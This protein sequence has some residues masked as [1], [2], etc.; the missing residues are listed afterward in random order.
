MQLQ[1]LVQE[2]ESIKWCII[3]SMRA[4]NVNKV[5]HGEQAP[6]PHHEFGTVSPSPLSSSINCIDAKRTNQMLDVEEPKR[7]SKILRPSSIPDFLKN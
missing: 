1:K 5:V 3:R 7:S 6:R 2:K 4:W